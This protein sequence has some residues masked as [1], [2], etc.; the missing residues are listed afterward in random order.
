MFKNNVF[1]NTLECFSHLWTITISQNLS[2]LQHWALFP[3]CITCQH[4]WG[5][6]ALLLCIS[7]NAGSIGKRSFYM[8]H[9]W[10]CDREKQQRAG[11][12]MQWLWRLWCGICVSRATGQSNRRGQ[13]Q[14]QWAADAHPLHTTFSKSQTSRRGHIPLL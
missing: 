1:I 11:R 12:N 2:G 8:T 7:S 13:T 6:D 4:L 10:F 5:A 14:C 9:N 3:E